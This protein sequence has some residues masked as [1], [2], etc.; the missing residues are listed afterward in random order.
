MSHQQHLQAIRDILNFIR[1]FFNGK[2]LSERVN[3]DVVFKLTSK[4][5]AYNLKPLTI[6]DLVT[7][8]ESLIAESNTFLAKATSTIYTKTFNMCA[9]QLNLSAKS[10]QM[11]PNDMNYHKF[12]IKKTKKALGRFIMCMGG[13]HSGEPDAALLHTLGEQLLA[14]SL[15]LSTPISWAHVEQTVD[16]LLKL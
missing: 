6:D 5:E 9:I 12:V 14:H 11:L 16:K 10:M 13:Q 1:T 15:T 8:T 3:E 2:S 7:F 4:I